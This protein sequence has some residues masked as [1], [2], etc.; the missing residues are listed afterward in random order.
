MSRGPKDGFIILL[1]E[2]MSIQISERSTCSYNVPTEKGGA[3]A[4][5][6]MN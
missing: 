1:E 6:F 5:P 2:A 3:E 4:P